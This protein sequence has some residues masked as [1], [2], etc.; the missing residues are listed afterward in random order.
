MWVDLQNYIIQ[1]L[2][3][4]VKL[5][6]HHTQTLPEKKKAKTFDYINTSNYVLKS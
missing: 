4:P 5:C 2:Q 1:F 3:T 6:F